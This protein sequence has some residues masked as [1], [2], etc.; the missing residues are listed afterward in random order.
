MVHVQM[1]VHEF[2]FLPAF[3][4][5]GAVELR[6]L[7]YWI[8]EGATEVAAGTSSYFLIPT[9]GAWELHWLMDWLTGRS[10]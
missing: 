5:E 10:A 4:K 1:S 2:L 3:G 7:I 6:R 9:E 8:E